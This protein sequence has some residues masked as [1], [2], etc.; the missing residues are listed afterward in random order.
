MIVHFGDKN[1]KNCLFVCLFVGSVNASIITIDASNSGWY[2]SSGFFN[3]TTGNI[4]A[5]VGTR[6]NWLGF[7]LS[8]ITDTITSATLEVFS[9]ASNDSGQLFTWSDVTTTYGDLGTV[10]GTSIFNDLGTGITY[11]TGVHTAGLINSFILN[12]AGIASLNATSSNWAIGGS[13]D[14][15]GGVDAFGFTGGVGGG[16]HI[17]LVLNTT[18]SVPEPASIALLGLGL[19]GIG[20]S[21]KKKTAQ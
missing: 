4:N 21:R 7:D 11:A 10:A 2:T 14:G 20:F 6:N 9:N 12:A 8:T 16:D 17:K 18:A 15:T 19:A 1:E 13:H 3:S 5:D